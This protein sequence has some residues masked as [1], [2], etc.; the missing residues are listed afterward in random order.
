MADLLFSGR[1]LLFTSSVYDMR[2]RAKAKRCS[3]GIH[4]DIATADND[5]F[6][7]P[8]DRRSRIVPVRVHEVGS[9]QILIG[10]EDAERLLT[11]NIHESGQSRAGADKDS[12]EALFLQKVINRSRTADNNVRLDFDA[13]RF[14][15]LD[16]LGDNSFLGKTEFGNAVDK[17]AAGFMQRLKNCHTVPELCKITSA[18]KSGR[19]GADDSNFLPVRPGAVYRAD[20]ELFRLVS[21]ITLELADGN[22]LSLDAADTLSLALRFL[23]ADTAADRWQRR[24]LADDLICLCGISVFNFLN[25]SGNID[26]YRAPLHTPWILAV[27]ASCSLCHCLFIVI[28]EAYFLKILRPD[29]RLLFTDRYF[30]HHIN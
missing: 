23:R 20:T 7:C 10:G 28:S 30:F 25:K 11:W 22:R 13:K 29:S 17:D 5:G 12:I 18:G 3:R 15:V 24:A 14:Y 26:R 4:C 27:Q 16:F 1:K 21:G 6:L 2:F 8:H 19:T 9:C